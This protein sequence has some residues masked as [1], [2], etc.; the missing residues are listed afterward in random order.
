M[1]D[2]RSRGEKGKGRHWDALE[3]I[4]DA[5]IFWLS[6]WFAFL[7]VMCRLSSGCLL[8][9]SAAVAPAVSGRLAATE[10]QCKRRYGL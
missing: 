9:P 4:Q 8:G 1:G 6:A 5:E 7:V 10:V 2:I 3:R